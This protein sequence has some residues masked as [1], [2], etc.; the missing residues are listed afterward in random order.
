M[1][2]SKLDIISELFFDNIIDDF[3]NNNLI[4]KPNKTM[5]FFT[6]IDRGI[7]DIKTFMKSIN[8]MYPN[9]T[10]L[11]VTNNFINI[12]QN[13]EYT[14]DDLYKDLKL[15][16]LVII[17][18]QSGYPKINLTPEEVNDGIAI[19]IVT[20]IMEQD[21]KSVIGSNFDCTNEWYKY[22]YTNY[23]YNLYEQK[24]YGSTKEYPFPKLINE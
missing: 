10:D 16:S 7:T 9:I 17:C 18:H 8:E 20:D 4:I 15:R 12:Y 22:I 3:N 5:V 1:D 2:I 14:F 23:L 24:A 6:Y 21:G 13:I 11:I 19:S